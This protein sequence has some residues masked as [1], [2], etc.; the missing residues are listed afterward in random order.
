MKMRH[1]STRSQQKRSTGR[2]ARSR[3]TRGAAAR[4]HG[5]RRVA[6]ALVA[7]LGGSVVS[8][9]VG[10]QPAL[11]G[12]QYV[13]TD[14][15]GSGVG[16]LP[17]A[18]QQADAAGP[19]SDTTITFDCSGTITVSATLQITS[20]MAIEGGGP[21]GAVAVSGGGSVPVFDVA[22]GV[23]ASV[24]DLT[25]ED[26]YAPSSGSGGGVSNSGTLTLEN[27]TITGNKAGN[28][29]GVLNNAG[30]TVTVTDS[31]FSGDTAS[32]D[33]GAIDNGDYGGYGTLTVT[34]STFSGDTGPLDGGAIDN[35][36]DGGIGTLA[37]TDSTFS[38]DTA[39][40][41]G[42]AIDNGDSAGAGTLTV[43]D[44][45]FSGNTASIHGGAIDDGDS[46]GTGYATVEADIFAGSCYQGGGSSWTDNGYNVGSDTSC[47]NGGTAD[48]SSAGSNL[49]SLLGPLQNNG[50]STGTMLPLPGNPAIGIVPN[51]TTGF[52]P[53]SDQRGVASPTGAACDAGSVQAVYD[54]VTYSAGTGSGTPPSPTSGLDG[55]SINLASPTGL[56]DPG[57]SFSGWN[58]G[59]ATYAAGATY[60]L[61]SGGA[62][63]TL[64]AQWTPLAP[65]YAGAAA[66]G[67]GDCSSAANA[68]SL[69]TALGDVAAG[70]TIELVTS[71]NE[72]DPSTFYSGGFSVSTPGTSAAF[73]VTIEPASGVTNP[74]LDGGHSQTVLTVG[75]MYLDLSGVTIQNGSSSNRGGGIRYGGGGM[76]SVTDSTFSGN[77]A[78]YTGGAIDNNVGGTLQVADSTFSGNSAGDAGGAIANGSNQGQLKGSATLT[79]TDS[80]FSGN[81]ASVDGGAIDN[82][83]SGIGALTVTDS[84]FSGNTASYDGGAIDNGDSGGAG[85]ATVEADIFAGS[86]YQGAGAGSSW[87]DKGYNVGSD[88]S[89]FNG[90]TADNSSA[91]S[92]LPSLLGPLQNNGGSTKTMLPLPGNPAIG[93]VPNGTT[94]FCPVTDQRGVASP[95]GS[96]CEAGSVQGAIDDVTYSAGT[97]SGTPPASTSGLDGTSLTLPTPSG[98][99]DPGYSFSGWNDGT[100]TYAAG[101]SY[102]LSS[103]GAPITLT[104]QWT[105]LVPSITSL[106]ASSGPSKGGTQF[107]IYGTNFTNTVTVEIG[108]GFGAG[109]TA[110]QATNVDVS[111]GEITLT[112][113]RGRPGTWNVFVINSTG[114]TSP[115][116]KADLFTYLG[117]VVTGVSPNSGPSKGG[118]SITITGSGFTQ[119]ATV[120]IGQG[121]GAGPTAVQATNVDV[122]GS[123]EITATTPSGNPGKWNVFVLE[124]NGTSYAVSADSFEYLGPVVTGVSPN[125]GP[126]TGETPIT[127]TGSGFTQDAT[128]EIGQGFGAGPTAVQATNVVVGSREITATTPSGKAG[129]W[130]V[131]VIEQN[132]TSRAVIADLFTYDGNPSA[133]RLGLGAL[134]ETE[135]RV[136]G[137]GRRLARTRRLA[138]GPLPG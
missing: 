119:D 118:T 111:P 45:T 61:S 113:P 77:S 30:G 120:E 89:C 49:S 39:L 109:P 108:Q 87:T 55:T 16:S 121:F 20:N 41:N 28:G 59:T 32:I 94:G 112:T 93:I 117:P 57:Y 96:A 80:T 83:D 131:F 97:G 71:G 12:T 11:A 9:L 4:G 86:C 53:V 105:P 35:G 63:I 129:R 122:V 124:Q 138:R 7:A 62:P 33:G 95:T 40:N 47:F 81:T 22:G 58:D 135:H 82:G 34:D 98:L 2:Q 100:A 127:I 84:T 79:V 73:P 68:C 125:S 88:T 21:A 10:T 17:N 46:G 60:E 133:A 52:C 1:R 67:T 72:N 136:A 26:G 8:V 50:G 91:G 48:N 78:T 107:T 43:T 13:V 102:E 5:A 19:N 103:G 42:G 76:L 69:S 15:T 56:S 104:A 51:G 99:S 38:G 123:R 6:A 116:G 115:A 3:T 24:S 65:L 23:T 74:I 18:V 70:Q 92:D 126:A 106:S 36:D 130:N 29:G 31:T 114:T 128:V 54:Q 101:A 132:G 134:L 14:C 110:V 66:Q 137:D 64:T 44:S 25:I 90:G 27:D 85:T 75:S 37:V